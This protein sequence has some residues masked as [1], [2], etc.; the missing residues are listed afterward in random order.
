[1]QGWIAYYGS[2]AGVELPAQV[3]QRAEAIE[4]CRAQQVQDRSLGDAGEVH[5]SDAP[6]PGPVA[7]GQAMWLQAAQALVA[8]QEGI[9]LDA[10][11]S[12]VALDVAMDDAW[13]LELGE[14][15][16]A[17][18][19]GAV[20]E[21]LA[22]AGRFADA[23]DAALLRPPVPG[24]TTRVRAAEAVDA[25]ELPRLAPA[26]A[27]A[28]RLIDLLGGAEHAV[29]RDIKTERGIDRQRLLTP[30]VADL[31]RQHLGGDMWL[32]VYPLRANGTVRFAAVRVVS[33]AKARGG[34]P[35]ATEPTAGA[36]KHCALAIVGEA[37][38]IGLDVMVSEE[39]GRGYV[40]WVPVAQPVTAARAKALATLLVQSTAGSEEVTREVIPAQEVTKPDKPG[41]PVMLPLGLDPRT[42][43][44]A[45]LCEPDLTRSLDPCALLR[46]FVAN[47]PERV[48]EALGVQR[49][50]PLPV[51][52]TPEG[53]A[54]AADAGEG[55]RTPWRWRR[56]RFGSL[57]ARR[58]C[59][60]AAPCYGISSTRRCAGTAWRVAQNTS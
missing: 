21:C 19:G 2:L 60:R 23:A 29:V 33:K 36:V 41:T 14:R 24:D 48:A 25:V 57:R 11:R 38:R 39:P 50:L 26:P 10:V 51:R 1:M 44:R 54:V 34:R 12:S 53:S 52:P 7:P 6:G 17:F 20:A 8:A 40:V 16:A 28:Q 46:A 55:G 5:V 13:W 32:G 15:L 4:A 30:L 42:G 56:R 45:W 22:R 31:V 18:D 3:R 27:D 9:T 37:R 58:I 59:T 47:A 49:K 35:L 43:E